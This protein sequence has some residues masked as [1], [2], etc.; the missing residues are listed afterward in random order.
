MNDMAPVTARPKMPSDAF[1]SAG[2]QQV[3]C[4]HDGVFIIPEGFCHAVENAIP[5]PDYAP[6]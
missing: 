6:G 2:G 3:G 5:E 4:N 1:N